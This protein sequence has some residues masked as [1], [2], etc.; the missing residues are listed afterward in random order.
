[1][2]NGDGFELAKSSFKSNGADINLWIHLDEKLN[3]LYINHE[4][5]VDI[6]WIPDTIPPPGLQNIT[7][8][9]QMLGEHTIDV[10]KLNTKAP[11]PVLPKSFWS[12]LWSNFKHYCGNTWYIKRALEYASENN[13]SA[14]NIFYYSIST[15][16]EI[17]NIPTGK[18]KI[19]VDF[20]IV[21]E[22]DVN[23]AD[24]EPHKDYKH[25]FRQVKKG[26]VLAG[27]HDNDSHWLEWDN[28]WTWND[29]ETRY[30]PIPTKEDLSETIPVF[31]S[32][33]FN[34]AAAFNLAIDVALMGEGSGAK[35]VAKKSGEAI[36][37]KEILVYA[38]VQGGKKFYK[39]Y[40]FEVMEKLSKQWYFGRTARDVAVRFNEH[41][42]LK[43]VVSKIARTIVEIDKSI[44]NAYKTMKGIEQVAI[45]FGRKE[46]GVISNKI[47]AVRKYLNKSSKVT[48]KY[49][50]CVN[51]AEEYLK[52]PNN[53]VGEPYREKFLETIQK[54]KKEF[55]F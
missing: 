23:L 48:E 43:E 51:F 4:A 16:L 1:M 5:N 42:R 45:E 26:V 29:K 35:F 55:D 44:P 11:P 40:A 12:N 3:V 34:G 46:Y 7:F 9:Y 41:K 39:V 14:D 10:S 19:V 53:K 2:N 54:L 37:E 52:N 33:Q 15:G 49:K 32:L 50:E 13:I 30:V 28:A 47:N 27:S 22:E 6:G 8:K 38:G 25:I 31:G 36:I 24:S 21:Q 18:E 20:I 17:I